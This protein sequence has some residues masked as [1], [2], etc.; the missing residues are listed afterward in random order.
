MISSP[1]QAV[2]VRSQAVDYHNRLAWQEPFSTLCLNDTQFCCTVQAPMGNH[3][4]VLGSRAGSLAGHLRN[5]FQEVWPLVDSHSSPGKTQEHENYWSTSA[6]RFTCATFF[7][8]SV[9]NRKDKNITL[10]RHRVICHYSNASGSS[11]I[12][13]VWIKSK[14]W[15]SP[16]QQEYLDSSCS[17]LVKELTE[18]QHF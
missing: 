17:T 8:Q 18:V 1:N 14:L 16:C 9:Q 3:Q 7:F 4:Q 11:V 10:R 15:S 12:V 5:P 13:S 6:P 2:S